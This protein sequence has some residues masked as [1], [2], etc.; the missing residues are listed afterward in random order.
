MLNDARWFNIFN[1]TKQLWLQD[2]EKSFGS[3]SVAA[4]FTELDTAKGIA[5]RVESQNDGDVIVVFA[6]MGSV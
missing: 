5:E 4:E 6:D 3:Y 1:A 2:D